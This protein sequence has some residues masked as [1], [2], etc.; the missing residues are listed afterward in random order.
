MKYL[1][2][3]NAI[4]AIIGVLV[5]G[6]TL[7][8][9]FWRPSAGKRPTIDLTSPRPAKTGINAKTPMSAP[10]GRR[11]STVPANR[12]PIG[13]SRETAQPNPGGLVTQPAAPAV[14]NERLPAAPDERPSAVRGT[15]GVVGQPGALG[16]VM[17]NQSDSLNLEEPAGARKV[18]PAMSPRRY[19]G[20]PGSQPR[21]TYPSPQISRGTKRDQSQT[22][23]NAPPPPPRSS[24][25]Q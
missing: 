17:E 7:L 13:G 24:M 10:Q 22:D 15:S 1:N 3:L 18:A 25:P 2:H 20:R 21:P 14:P 5:I 16:G 12:A 8:D 9:T 4:I 23:P 19:T 11:S 6:N